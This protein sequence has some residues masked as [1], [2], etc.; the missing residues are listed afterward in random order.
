MAVPLLSEDR[1]LG[2]LQVLDRQKS[3]FTLQQMDLLG[4]FANQAAIALDLLQRARRAKRAVDRTDGQ[5][6]AVARIAEAMDALPEER[7]DAGVRLL[8]ALEEV[9]A[10]PSEEPG[11]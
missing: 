6:G 5:V 1:A 7:R 2:V 11:L 4:L 9:L 8:T 10:A 3:R